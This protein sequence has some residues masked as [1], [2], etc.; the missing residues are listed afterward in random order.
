MRSLLTLAASACLALA[1]APSPEQL[2]RDAVAAQQRGDDQAAV[3]RYEQ[4]LKLRPDV[5]EV[6]AN[7]GAAFARLGRLDQAIIQYRVA[8]ALSPGNS[9]LRLNLALAFYKLANWREAAA[10]LRPLHAASPAD[11]RLTTL[12]ADCLARLGNHAEAI[13]LLEPLHSASPQDLS[14][15]WLLGSSLIQAGRKQ[16]GLA[17]VR[18]VAQNGNSA[19]AWLLAGQTA[20]QLNDFE[21]ARDHAAAAARLNPSLPGLATL[22]GTVLQYLGDNQSSIEAFRKAL[23]ANPKDFDAQLG[24]GAVLHTERDLPAARR[25]LEAALKLNAASNLAR[26]QM[27]RLERTE[28]KLQEAVSNLEKVVQADPGWPQPHIELSALY[29]RLNRKEDGEK[30][31]AIFDRLNAA[32]P[33]R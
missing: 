16:E 13:A 32:K 9:A 15:A 26:Y 20:L 21:T 18:L 33:Q 31:R 27:A 28:G 8:L 12:L 2:F 29:F 14:V 7:L 1:Q 19:E 10:T 6:R 22:Q 3:A 5:V 4:L 24:L 17:L 25:H 11:A 23:G 30:E